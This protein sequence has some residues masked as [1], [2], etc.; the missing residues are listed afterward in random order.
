MGRVKNFG[1]P[2][3]GGPYGIEGEYYDL[4]PLEY[5]ENVF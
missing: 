2:G 5:K 3:S 4:Y 1:T